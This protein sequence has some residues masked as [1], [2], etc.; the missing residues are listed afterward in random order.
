[1]EDPE[2]VVDSLVCPG[3][4]LHAKCASILK[5]E[6][7]PGISELLCFPQL[8]FTEDAQA[9]EGPTEVFVLFGDLHP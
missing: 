2:H 1:M 3:P 6:G 8:A 9:H 7:V 5:V 4:V